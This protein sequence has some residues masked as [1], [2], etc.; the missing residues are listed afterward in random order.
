MITHVQ[1][2]KETGA[3]CADSWPYGL[4]SPSQG[5][6]KGE[7]LADFTGIPGYPASTRLLSLWVS[8]V[9]T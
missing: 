5:K 7:G 8:M 9:F 2:S 6:L 3:K 4:A 1:I